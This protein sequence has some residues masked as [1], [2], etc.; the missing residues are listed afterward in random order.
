MGMFDEVV[1][2][3]PHCSGQITVQ[4]KAGPRLL[5][6]YVAD[7]V[8]TAIAVDLSGQ[9]LHCDRCSGRWFI[10]VKVAHTVPCD[11]IQPPQTDEEEDTVSWLKKE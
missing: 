9:R 5:R 6:T 2:T 3:C 8:P 4:S 1:F 10:R 11:L 7:D